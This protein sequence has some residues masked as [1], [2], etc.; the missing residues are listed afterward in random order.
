MVEFALQHAGPRRRVPVRDWSVDWV[1]DNVPISWTA[2]ET[3][4]ITVTASNDGGRVWPATGTNPVRLGYKWI[5]NATGNVF[6]GANRAPLAVDVQ[7]GQTVNLIIPIT[8]PTYPTNYTLYI[9]LYKENEFAFEDKGVAPDDTPTGVSVDFKA[10]YDVPVGRSSAR[11]RS[12]PDRSRAFRSR[13]TN[14]G[15]GTFPVTSSFPVNLGYHWYNAAGAAVVWDGSRHEAARDLASGQSVNLTAQVA[16]P[17]QPGTYFLRFDLV[18][19]GVAWFSLKGA[20][21]TNFSVTV[22]GQLVPRVRRV[23]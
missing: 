23:V 21:P 3:K 11:L 10:N 22:A 13:C 7:P 19:E 9:D 16:A 12:P 18:Q 20:A 2:G 8:A 4:I 6:P 15:Q 14:A 1:K 17:T 5:S